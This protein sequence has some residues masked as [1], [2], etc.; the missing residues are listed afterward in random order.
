MLQLVRFLHS[1]FAHYIITPPDS[2]DWAKQLRVS[3]FF[4]G[5]KRRGRSAH[6]FTFVRGLDGSHFFK[7]HAHDAITGTLTSTDTR[8]P[9]ARKRA[10]DEEGRERH[11]G[12]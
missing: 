11:R 8:Q 6:V 7:D 5:W 10:A 1:Y 3:N 12:E 2:P 9:V 4:H